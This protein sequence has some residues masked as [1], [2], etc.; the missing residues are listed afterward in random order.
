MSGIETKDLKGGEKVSSLLRRLRAEKAGKISGGIYH[1]TQID[2]TYNS[3]HIEGCRLSK[4]QTRSIYET[5]TLESS[6]ETIRVDDI[7]ETVN[8]FRCIDY[9]I[10]HA[11]E[12]I[13]EAHVKHLHLL[14]KANTSDSDEDWF[15]VGD[16]KKIPNEVGGAETA[17]PKDVHRRMNALLSSYGAIG[18]VNFDA[19]YSTLRFTPLAEKR[20]LSL[21]FFKYGMLKDELK[22][23]DIKFTEDFS[24]A[25]EL[26]GKNSDPFSGEYLCS[27]YFLANCFKYIKEFISEKIEVPVEDIRFRVNMG[28]PFDNLKTSFRKIYDDCLRLGWI[29]SKDVVDG[30]DLADVYALIV[31]HRNDE[32]DIPLQT[33]PE[34]YAEVYHLFRNNSTK[35]GLY[36]ILDI[37]GGTADF[38]VFHVRLGPDGS[39]KIRFLTQNVLPLGVEMLCTQIYPKNLE[40]GKKK[41]RGENADIVKV[42]Y[43]GR[44]K[45]VQVRERLPYDFRCGIFGKIVSVKKMDKNLL[46]NIFHDDGRIPLLLYGGGAD[47]KWYQSIIKAHNPSLKNYNIPILDCR[48]KKENKNRLIIAKSLAFIQEVFDLED[49]DISFSSEFVQ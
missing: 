45:L 5:R 36:G 23:K 24:L 37:G 25:R 4:E 20:L 19:E 1:R 27:V 11:E 22:I 48:C 3:N 13:T 26:V 12:S 17:L 8:H 29:L 34:L 30:M 21:D 41:I 28:C 43:G 14:L 47:F 39:R 15:A 32:T 33:I 16:Y 40:I 9:V 18:T 31:A 6:S 2:L 38:A 44:G 35:I 46:A 7:M 42:N 10:E 49:G